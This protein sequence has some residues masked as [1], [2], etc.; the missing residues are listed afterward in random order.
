VPFLQLT[1]REEGGG[2][3]LG[4]FFFLLLSCFAA[5]PP[6]RSRGQPLP[7]KLNGFN[8]LLVFLAL[9][10]LLHVAGIYALQQFY[11]GFW[12]N[13]AAAFVVGLTASA[14]LYVKGSRLPASQQVGVRVCARAH[15]GRACLDET[16]AFLPILSHGYHGS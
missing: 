11:Q 4:E 16:C 9:A 14:T 10:I 1:Q 2:I 6:H 15:I 13:F 8:V 7:Y 3:F 5:H 12:A